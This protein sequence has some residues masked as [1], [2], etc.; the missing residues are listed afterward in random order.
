M[1]HDVVG[2]VLREGFI[3]EA[4]ALYLVL[5]QYSAFTYILFAFDLMAGV[6]SLQ[7]ACTATQCQ[8]G[9]GVSSEAE[10]S[11]QM[12]GL[13]SLQQWQ[14]RTSV[15]ATHTCLF[16]EC[17]QVSDRQVCELPG[18]N[19]RSK[20]NSGN[21]CHNSLMAALAQLKQYN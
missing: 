10:A 13:A 11:S 18:P 14:P 15:T 17:Q 5:N 2:A 1:P 3:Q 7:I 19:S 20:R 16:T 6:D 4:E 9:L 21:H 12:E 8:D